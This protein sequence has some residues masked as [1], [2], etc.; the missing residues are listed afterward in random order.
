MYD[1]LKHQDQ[2]SVYCIFFTVEQ[3]YHTFTDITK[4][5][6]LV[7]ITNLFGCDS[8]NFLVWVKKKVSEECLLVFNVLL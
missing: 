2:F 8:L 3:M 1:F 7:L 5:K 6:H 4:Q